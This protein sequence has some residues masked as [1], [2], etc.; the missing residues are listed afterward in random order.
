LQCRHYILY[1]L[2]IKRPHSTNFGKE[3][4][5]H[6]TLLS[7]EYVTDWHVISSFCHSI[8]ARSPPRVHSRTPTIF[9]LYK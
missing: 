4:Y 7:V 3:K 2:K 9:G 8:E 1:Y 5:E 6:F